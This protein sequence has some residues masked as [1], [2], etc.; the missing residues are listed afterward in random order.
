MKLALLRRLH[1]TEAELE[2]LISKHKAI[3]DLC[4]K[5]LDQ[6]NEEIERLKTELA[7]TPFPSQC[8]RSTSA[9]LIR[10]MFRS[11]LSETVIFVDGD[12]IW[13]DQKRLLLTS[14]ELGLGKE[15]SAFRYDAKNVDIAPFKPLLD[16]IF[17]NAAES[18]QAWPKISPLAGTFQMD[19]VALSYQTLQKGG[20]AA[21]TGLLTAIGN[22]SL[23]F[24]RPMKDV[25]RAVVAVANGDSTKWQALDPAVSVASSG[26]CLIFRFG[27]QS[28]EVDNS[29]PGVLDYVQTLARAEPFRSASKDLVIYDA[30]RICDFIKMKNS[31]PN[32]RRD[33]S[34]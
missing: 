27:D 32:T 17:D 5:D 31:G 10:A 1:L 23:V 9:S 4:R 34:D 19:E 25:A 3:R 22:I 33:L 14:L 20:W 21:N 29:P 6:L 30:Y 28:V 26:N 18:N 15:R 12:K 8:R 16:T 2:E 7:A 24:H 13:I 11:I